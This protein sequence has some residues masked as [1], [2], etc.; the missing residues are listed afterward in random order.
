MDFLTIQD[1]EKSL[2]R[3]MNLSMDWIWDVKT[4]LETGQ[5]V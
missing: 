4:T 1:F 2:E 3:Y 5:L